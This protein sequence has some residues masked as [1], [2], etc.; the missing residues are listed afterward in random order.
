MLTV[1]P[2]SVDSSLSPMPSNSRPCN[3]MEPVTRAC[4]GSRPITASD[5]TDLPEPDSPTM[6][7][8]SP[9]ETP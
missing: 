4:S 5:A 2:R 6:A 7:S 1:F 3:R 8:T 9:S